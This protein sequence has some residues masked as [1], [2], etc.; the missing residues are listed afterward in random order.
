MKVLRQTIFTCGDVTRAG[1]SR[2]HLRMMIKVL[3][4]QRGWTQQQLAEASGVE[5][6]TISRAE[7]GYEGTTLRTLTSLAEALGVSAADLLPDERREVEA[8]LL[9]AFRGLPEAQQ[10][11]W[12]EM[13]E[14]LGQSTGGEVA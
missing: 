12:L 10:E 9:Q 8:R 4:K 1:P 13:V 11:Y 6:V 2:Y 5:P 7:N 14:A 3:R